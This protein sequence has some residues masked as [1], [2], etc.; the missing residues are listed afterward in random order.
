MSIILAPSLAQDMRQDAVHHCRL[1]ATRPRLVMRSNCIA[2]DFCRSPPCSACQAVSHPAGM[3]L[4]RS[5]SEAT[6]GWLPSR[7]T[8]EFSPSTHQPGHY[9]HIWEP[10]CLRSS[11]H[12]CPYPCTIHRSPMHNRFRRMQSRRGHTLGQVPCAL[13]QSNCQ[14][15]GAWHTWNL[16]SPPPNTLKPLE[17]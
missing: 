9:C 11:C 2:C 17:L 7:L 6:N 16:A 12:T 14:G 15:K 1:S 3:A 5:N 13:Q 10:A 8:A 4:F